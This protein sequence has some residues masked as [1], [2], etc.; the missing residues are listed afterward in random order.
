MGIEIT[1]DENAGRIIEAYV[2]STTQDG[3]Y[4]KV[5]GQI[6]TEEWTCSCPAG[7]HRHECKHIYEVRNSL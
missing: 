2:E 6:A 1:K 4:Y 5:T 7:R 3:I